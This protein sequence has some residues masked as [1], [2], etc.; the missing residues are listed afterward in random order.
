MQH[1]PASTFIHI[2]QLYKNRPIN[3]DF[4]WFA[5]HANAAPHALRG[6]KGIPNGA[7]LISFLLSCDPPQI[8]LGSRSAVDSP[9]DPGRVWLS[10]TFH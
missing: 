7:V 8:H 3:V 1:T 4:R 5:A 9:P 10:K 6:S 2:L